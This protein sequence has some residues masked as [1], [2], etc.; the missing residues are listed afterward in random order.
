MLFFIISKLYVN[1]KIIETEPNQ[2]LIGNRFLHSIT[3][4]KILA[5]YR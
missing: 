4:E 3:Y 5:S 2:S 1:L